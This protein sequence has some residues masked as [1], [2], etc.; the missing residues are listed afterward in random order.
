MYRRCKPGKQTRQQVGL[1]FASSVQWDSCCLVVFWGSGI[2]CKMKY[3][4]MPR[5]YSREMHE[6]C[7]VSR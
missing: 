2:Y 6:N 5:W 3:R 7:K 1:V 4:G